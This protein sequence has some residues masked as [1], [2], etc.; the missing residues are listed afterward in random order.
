MPYIWN[1]YQAVNW[2]RAYFFIAV[3]EYKSPD[4]FRQVQRNSEKSVRGT[5]SGTGVT[6]CDIMSS[7]KQRS[8]YTEGTTEINDLQTISDRTVDNSFIC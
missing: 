2:S 7:P 3:I 1:C 4:E 5:G 8:T 6:T